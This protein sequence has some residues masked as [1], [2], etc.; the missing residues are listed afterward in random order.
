MQCDKRLSASATAGDQ[1]ER[2]LDKND[3]NYGASAPQQPTQCRSSRQAAR[4]CCSK[5]VTRS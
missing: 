4:A 5:A 3:P 2:V 1:A